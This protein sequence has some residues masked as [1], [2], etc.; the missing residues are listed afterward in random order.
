MLLVL[1][2]GLHGQNTMQSPVDLGTKNSSFT[3]GNT[4]NTTIYTNNYSGRSTNDVFYKFTLFVPMEITVSHCGSGLSDTYVH[5]LS[6]SGSVIVSVDD[7]TG[8]G[9]CSNTYHPVIKR[10]LTA[11]TYYVVSEGYSSNGN[12][13]TSIAGTATSSGTVDIGTKSTSFTY[14]DTKNTTNTGNN[15]TGRS[16]NDILYK[17]ILTVPMEITA[18][19]C[20]SGLND[21]YMTLLDASQNFITHVDDYSGEGKCSNTYH[22]VI[23]R[24]LTAGTYFIVSEGYGGNG[25]I[26]T[27][28]T[29]SINVPVTGVSLDQTS[30]YLTAIDQTAQLTAT[31]S[32]SNA[33][34]QN[35]NWSS[36]NP[37]VATVSNSG[38]V[39]AITP[40]LA[41]ITATTAD[42]NRTGICDI[43]VIIFPTVAFIDIGSQSTNFTYTDTKNTANTFNSYTERAPNDVTYEFLLAVPMEVTIT[44]CGS[45]LNDTYMTLL[46]GSRNIVASADDYTGEGKCSNTGHPVIKRQLEART[47]FIV[48]EGSSGN[49]SI[50]TTITGSINVPVTGVSLNQTNLSLTATNRTAQLTATVSPSNA[51][52]QTVTWSSSNSAV[53]TVSNSGLVTAKTEGTATITATTADG[54]RTATCATTVTLPIDSY[55]KANPISSNPSAG[56]N[57]IKTRTYTSENGAY[58][59]DAVQYYDGLGRP[60]QT[61][62]VGITPSQYDLVTLQEYDNF[63]RENNIWLPAVVSGNNGAFV[64]GNLQNMSRS[65]NGDQSPYSYPVYEPSPLN[66]VSEQYGPGQNWHAGGKSV[67]TEYL[68][69]SDSYPCAYYY[70]DGNNLKRNNNYGNGQLYVIK[71]TDEEGNVSYEFRDKLGRIVL[72]RQTTGRNTKVDTYYIYDDFGNLRFVLPPLATDATSG[73]SYT[74]DEPAIKNYAYV[75]KYDHRNRCI[76]KRLPGCEPIYY[77]YDKADRLLFSQDGEQRAK[78]EWLFSIPDALGRIVMTGIIHNTDFTV[79][80]ELQMGLASWLVSSDIVEC[81]KIGQL[82]LYA[83]Y[84]ETGTYKGYK[85]IDNGYLTEISPTEETIEV[86]LEN[87]ATFLSVNYYD[88]YNFTGKNNIPNIVFDSGAGAEFNR[89]YTGGYKGLLTGTLTAVLDVNTTPD[90]YLYSV[91]FYDYRGQVIQTVSSNHL[92]GTEKEYIAYTFT[93]QPEKR[94]HVHT[95]P[96]KST[97]TETYGYDYDHAERLV[98]TRHTLNSGQEILM[99][100]NTYDELGRL[101]TTTPHQLEN[102]KST[103]AYNIRSWISKTGTQNAS[104]YTEDLT[105]KYNGNVESKQWTQGGTTRKYT[106]AYDGLSRLVEASGGNIQGEIY[107]GYYS[108]DKHGNIYLIERYG[109]ISTGYFGR[110]DFLTLNYGGSNQLKYVNDAGQ[111]VLLSTSYDFKNYAS[112]TVEY[113]YNANGAMTKDM[114]K[115]ISDITYNVLNLPLTVDIKSPVAE[116]RNEYSYS[117]GGQKLKVVRKWPSSYSTTPVIGSAV[118]TSALNNSKTIDYAGNIIY[119][120]GSLKEILTENGY[121]DGGNYYFYV[122]NHLGSNVM[123]INKNTGNSAQNNHYYPFGLTMSV[124]D[125][126]GVQPY[127]YTGK[128]LDMEHGLMQYDFEAR[129]YDPA[130]G[131]FLTVDPLA[132]KYPWLSPYAYCG[133]NS[134]RFVDPDGQDI[135]EINDRGEIIKRMKD[136]TQDAFFMVAKDAGGNYQRTFTTDAEGNKNYNSISFKHKTVESQKSISFS[137]DGKTTGTYD[138]YQVRGDANATAMFEFMGQHVTGSPSKVEFSQAKTGIEG[139]KGLNFITTSHQAGRD[140]GMSEL[141]GKRLYY[142]YNIRELNHTHPI[143]DYPSGRLLPQRAGDIGFA[144]DVIDNRDLLHLRIP[145]FNIYHVPTKRY[146]PY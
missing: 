84:T 20:G 23:K 8:E 6:A 79:T 36:D 118:N 73:S 24:Q 112:E 9:K 56:Q 139:D 31:V 21:T 115:G 7:Y 97:Q 144:A 25:S 26:T 70:M 99:S 28:I 105:Y 53:A 123:V 102:F 114:N 65:A 66:R 119:E 5:L 34:N 38:L 146:I 83:K 109:M 77:V 69:N 122:K 59:M 57:Y 39:T 121:Y 94:K 49:G 124:S 4:L 130:V 81:V 117:A 67:K 110:I 106:F 142:G 61:V 131:R 22:P 100:Q 85:I 141:I 93:G 107:S 32:P 76:W 135:W 11:G 47:Y 113:D 90:T 78:G 96:G 71:A 3:F 58:Y 27:T 13:T 63:G 143:S 30:I 51:T 89:Q 2:S 15:Y 127:K 88:N 82:D 50:T 41:T 19:H 18:T 44:H 134:L 1:A 60:I 103:Y 125:N 68:A 133:N 43:V 52:N 62:Q 12:I 128:E 64:T 98:R 75:Y 14:T 120:D 17:F 72:Q 137:P 45:R 74:E 91:F 40:G 140:E 108:Y 29:G 37:A 48:S 136:R 126:Q 92:G 95:A 16:P 116:A 54:N 35:V 10:Q 55:V 33:T 42:G 111:E 145:T 129:T 80:D 138:V 104:T 132:E 87:N 86:G 101:K 46:D